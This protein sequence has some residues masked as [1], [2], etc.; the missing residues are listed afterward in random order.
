MYGNTFVDVDAKIEEECR[1]T[2][3]YL[4]GYFDQKLYCEKLSNQK[5]TANTVWPIYKNN[6]ILK[7]E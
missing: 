2:I 7:A 1:R 3:P 5:S 6:F 4:Q